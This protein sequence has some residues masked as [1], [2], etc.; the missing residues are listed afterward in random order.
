MQ[1]L[2]TILLGFALIAITAVAQ[3]TC[4]GYTVTR[5]WDEAP[6]AMA[7]GGGTGPED[8]AYNPT[9]GLLYVAHDQLNTGTDILLEYT[10]D[11]VLLQT[12]A[13]TPGT[14][15]LCAMPS[16]PN[17]LLASGSTVVEIDPT[18][19]PVV[20]GASANV[21][22]YGNIQ[23]IDFDAL[24]NLWIHDGNSGDFSILNLTTGVA[25]SQ[26]VANF[27]SQ[28]LTFTPAGNIA[29]AAAFFNTGPYASGTYVELDVAGT[30]QCVGFATDPRLTNNPDSCAAGPAFTLVNGMTWIDVTNELAISSFFAV[31]GVNVA[32]LA[33]D[34]TARISKVGQDGVRNDAL[35]F[36]AFCSGDAVVGTAGFTIGVRNTFAGDTIVWGVSLARDCLNPTVGTNGSTLYLDGSPANLI[37]LQFIPTATSTFSIPIDLTLV[38][39]SLAGAEVWSQF[40]GVDFSAPGLDTLLTA[41]FRVRFDLQ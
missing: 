7:A 31:Q 36:E 9:S 28:C 14:G 20:G 15:G 37:L 23:D 5:A 35:V 40:A 30:V 12:N 29:V 32:R 8:I 19:A 41:A 1:Q 16:S 4:P 38:A 10:L 24:G 13:M 11:G 25:T 33:P 27:G 34:G 21:S 18:G 3:P 39:P 22:G 17:L 2:L 26:F 6:A